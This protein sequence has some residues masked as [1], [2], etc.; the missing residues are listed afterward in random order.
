MFNIFSH[1]YFVPFL[2]CLHYVSECF[3]F[4]ERQLIFFFSH[5]QRLFSNHFIL[6]HT[7]PLLQSVP[8]T[9]HN[10]FMCV[11]SQGFYD[12]S[13]CEVKNW[14]QS[15][16]L[17]KTPRIWDALK[18]RHPD[19]TVFVNGLWHGMHDPNIDFFVNVRPQYLQN[20]GKIADIYTHPAGLREELQGSLGTFPLHRFWGPGTSIE[21]SKWVADATIAVDKDSDPTL[22]L[23]YLPHLDYGLQKYGPPLT[24]GVSGN[25]PPNNS[26]S[27]NVLKDLQEI[28]KVLEELVGYYESEKAGTRVVILSEYAIARVERPVYL[29]RVLRAGGLVRVRTENGGE[30]LDCGECRA[31][32]L[33]DHQVT[34]CPCMMHSLCDD[35]V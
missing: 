17:V 11:R 19:A 2:W 30:T 26:D 13:Y 12:R 15:S 14:H 24:S 16:K 10:F 6:Q 20:G 8:K 31:F 28:D 23:L 18:A 33:C 7:Q 9:P 4:I 5:G 27:K 35:R 21:S 1:F 22:T 29:N 3:C 32:A 34:C 25:L